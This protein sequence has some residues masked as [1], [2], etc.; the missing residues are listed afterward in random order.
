MIFESMV[1]EESDKGGVKAIVFDFDSTLSSPHKI[2]RFGQWAIADKIDILGAMT[3]AE[4]V[5]NF[6]GHE[7][8]AALKEMLDAIQSNAVELFI[9]SI[10]FKCALVPHLEKVGISTYFQADRIWGQDS[11]E[12]RA[13]SYVKSALIQQIMTQHGWNK[14][15]MMFVDDSANHILKAQD[16]CLTLEVAGNGLSQA[17]MQQLMQVA[18]GKTFQAT[19][20][21]ATTAAERPAPIMGPS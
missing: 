12:L 4:I 2:E 10:G 21:T 7:R 13:V 20:Q 9:I 5:T 18:A 8:I 15:N 1:V 19:G 6:G 3:D 14:S 16:T 11:I 17:E